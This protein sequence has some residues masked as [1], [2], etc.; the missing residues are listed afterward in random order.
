MAYDAMAVQDGG[1]LRKGIELS[2]R[3]QRAIL[4]HSSFPLHTIQYE[5]SLLG[6]L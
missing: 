3:L 6:V 2:K 4:R 5:I 1:Q